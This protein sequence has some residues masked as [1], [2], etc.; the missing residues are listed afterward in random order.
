LIRYFDTSFLAP[1]FRKESTTARVGRFI[2]GLPIG[3]LAISRWTEVEFASLLARDVRVGAIGG[4]DARAADALFEE[5]VQQSFIVLLLGPDDY[6]LA[7]DYLFVFESGL[8]A[9][10]ALHLAVA[11]NHRAAAIYT[12]DKTMIAAGKKLGLPVGDGEISRG[13]P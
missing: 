12:L 3:E 7:K 6:R 10:D 13:P 5:V 2:A 1:L 11:A 8:R 4:D 9:G